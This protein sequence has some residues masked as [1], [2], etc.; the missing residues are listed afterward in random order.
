MKKILYLLLGVA[1]CLS[2]IKI[3]T[4]CATIGAEFTLKVRN[5]KMNLTALEQL[6]TPD[7]CIVEKDYITIQSQHDQRVALIA[8]KTNSKK[9]TTEYSNAITIGLPY[10]LNERRIPIASTIKPQEYDWKSSVKTDLTFLKNIGVLE[11][12]DEDIKTISG[13]AGQG[14]VIVYCKDKWQ[15]IQ[16]SCDCKDGKIICYRC[17]GADPLQIFLPKASLQK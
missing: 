13:L 5:I 7:T 16:G 1:A 3:A 4:A 8:Y 10:T 15:S 2:I 12:S 14:G 6:C 11:I 9:S 17:G